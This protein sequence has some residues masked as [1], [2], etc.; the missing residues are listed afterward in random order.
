ML[1]YEQRARLKGQVKFKIAR[2][3][4][5]LYA[6]CAMSLCSY[7]LEV[8]K[9]LVVFF[10][11]K[12]V[13]SSS[14][15]HQ[16]QAAIETCMSFWCLWLKRPYLYQLIVTIIRHT[17]KIQLLRFL[18]NPFQLENKVPVLLTLR[19]FI[20]NASSWIRQIIFVFSW[21]ALPGVWWWTWSS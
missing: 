4:A 21:S 3:S 20:S 18:Y 12:W 5:E 1:V 2:H 16:P 14:T 8:Q 17:R 10:I 13:W 11:I 19:V 9:V 6:S 15:K 7:V